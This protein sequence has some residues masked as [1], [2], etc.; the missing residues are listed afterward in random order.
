MLRSAGKRGAGAVEGE[1]DSVFREK[2]GLRGIKSSGSSQNLAQSRRELGYNSLEMLFERLGAMVQSQELQFLML[3]LIAVD[4]LSGFYRLYAEARGW[5]SPFLSILEFQ[6]GLSLLLFTLEMSLVLISFRSETFSH[7]GYTLDLILVGVMFYGVVVAAPWAVSVRLLNILRSWRLVRMIGAA[8][9]AQVDAHEETL[10]ELDRAEE[11][12]ESL[13]QK[14]RRAELSTKRESEKTRRLELNFRNQR[15]ELE[16]MREA[17]QIA[18]QTM[19]RA[20]GLQ[21]IADILV[22]EEEEEGFNSGPETS[23]EDEKNIGDSDLAERLK[24]EEQ[25]IVSKK[26]AKAIEGSQRNQAQV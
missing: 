2:E 13:K 4:F 11:R 16:T 22:Q 20:Q 12:I 15:S 9:Q 23:D 8:M 17:L 3:L 19:A 26:F 1:D 21:G 24:S 10:K 6:A 5:S 25:D 18:A 7:F 14:L